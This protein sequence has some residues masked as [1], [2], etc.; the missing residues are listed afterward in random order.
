MN[1]Q[2]F[3]TYFGEIFAKNGLQKYITDENTEKFHALTEIMIETN[4]VMNITALTTPEKIVPLHYADCVMA[5]KYIPEGARVIDVG[6]GGGFPILPLAIVRPDLQLTGLD[7]TDKKVQYVAK[8]AKML[9]L[10]IETLSGRA[11]ELVKDSILR[12]AFDVAISRAVA[13]LNVLD[14][15]CLPF[16][17]QNGLFLAMK[18]GAGQE[19][20]DEAAV[21]IAKL[22]GQITQIEA[23][24]LYLDTETEERTAICIR[25]ISATPASY[26]RPF[27][28]IKKKPL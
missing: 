10:N 9:G 27:G 16:V 2:E 13:R 3:S 15:L 18:G 17:K 20:A 1:K 7:S 14:E 21:G 24:K 22:G 8:T 4:R 28:N 5:A 6:C 23:Y 26:P 19:E 25:K 12:E 11:E